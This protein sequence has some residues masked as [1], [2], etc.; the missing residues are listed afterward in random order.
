MMSTTT[1]H[2]HVSP[3]PPGNAKDPEYL[4]LLK[5]MQENFDTRLTGEN[6][7]QGRLFT[8]RRAGATTNHRTDLWETY[9][10][11]FPEA[12]RQH[13]NCNAC[14]RFIERFGGLVT[15]DADGLS[16]PVFWGP[17]GD[18]EHSEPFHKLF[19]LVSRSVVDGVFVHDTSHLVGD[20]DGDEWI[21]LSVSLLKHPHL[22]HSSKVQTHRQRMAELRQ[23]F[24]QVDRILKEY[25]PKTFTLAASI[26]G[27]N[28]V[29]RAEKV[30]GVATWL[31][32]LA[33]RTAGPSSSMRSNRIWA[34]VAAAPAGYAHAR[35]S[36]IGTLLE[37]IHGNLDLDSIKRR[38]AEK[39]H[40][41]Q[42]RRPQA[43]PAAGAIVAAEKLVEK[44]GVERSFER[45]Y[46]RL[47]ELELSWRPANKTS[48][49]EGPGK[50]IFAGIQP[51]GEADTAPSN[52]L[53]DLAKSVTTM[54]WTKFSKEVLPIAQRMTVR[55]HYGPY[56]LIVFTTAVHA[57]APPILQWDRE[58]SRNPV[59]WYQY[60]GG[61]SPQFFS[62]AAGVPVEVVGVVDLPC[63]WKGSKSSN[64]ASRAMLVLQGKPEVGRHGNGIFP[65]C[66]RSELHGIRSVVEAHARRSQLPDAETI[67][68][69][70]CIAEEKRPL[71]HVD[72]VV[73]ANGVDRT[74]R[75][76]RWD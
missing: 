50:G 36:M 66:L 5:R 16:V 69:G 51:K 73:T 64:F 54:T 30:D 25:Q 22:V 35:S 13:H 17:S 75:I 34:A 72:F 31:S 40:P 56:P 48:V 8:T 67:P 14:R 24:E 37:D 11:S 61:S 38:F 59:A 43:A 4:A 39:M 42:Y 46:A 49:V 74:Y 52:V 20:Y 18:H 76:D 27:S 6:G 15:I 3:K 19:N 1:D 44:L 26:T 29:A 71:P 21:H 2:V 12:D 32:E 41:L 65:E 9:L 28:E 10:A 68:V 23:D 47:D 53:S 45:R 33:M 60:N 63:F 7:H 58:D 57:D 55:L 62:I 70:L